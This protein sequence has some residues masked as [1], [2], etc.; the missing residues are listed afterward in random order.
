M[1]ANSTTSN[2]SDVMRHGSRQSSKSLEFAIPYTIASGT[3]SLFGS[4][5]NLFVMV[6]LVKFVGLKQNTY[7]YMFS[8]FLSDF[9][10]NSLVQPQ[11]SYYQF[12]ASVITPFGMSY[13]HAASYV[14]ILSG[15]LNLFFA[16]LD[17]YIVIKYP[18]FYG[19]HITKVH[20]RIV[21]FCIWLVCI[22]LGVLRFFGNVFIK[23]S[24][25]VIV[26]TSFLLTI[27][28]QIMIYVVARNQERRIQEL[29]RSLEHNHPRE[30]I[31]QSMVERRTS[32]QN[33]SKAAKTIGLMLAVYIAS[34]LPVN[35]YRQHYKWFG[36]DATVFHKWIKI[37]NLMIQFHSCINPW[38]FVHRS[39]DMKIAV[40][41][42]LKS[43]GISCCL[44]TD[45][46][47][48][49][50]KIVG[51]NSNHPTTSAP[52]KGIQNGV[53]DNNDVE[54][55]KSFDDKK[56]IQPSSSGNRVN[57][58]GQVNTTYQK[59]CENLTGGLHVKNYI[60]N[61]SD[62]NILEKV[63][64]NSMNESSHIIKVKI[65]EYKEEMITGFNDS[66]HKTRRN[67]ISKNE[68]VETRK[69]DISEESERN[70]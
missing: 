18:F 34:W 43:T 65:E 46:E 22:V 60:A 35:L 62:N 67:K 29:H 25:P 44:Q 30:N 15:T 13:I 33:T 45:E 27:L 31:E 12:P 64:A 61:D 2:S 66:G 1:E 68:N 6:M 14:C 39:K 19:N 63:E 24:Y 59:S 40:T 5:S 49:V 3:F 41:K 58:E 55:M 32:H 53:D 70:D 23:E 11:V 50:L 4:V 21:V 8:L 69:E 20:T 48:T 17:K 56:I 57:I 42:F 26:L 7:L 28:T 10:Y 37:I 38:V 16:S 9:L 52:N 54:K 36:G 47:S 51:S